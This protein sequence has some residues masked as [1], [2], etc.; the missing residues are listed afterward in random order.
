MIAES[1]KQKKRYNGVDVTLRAIR[2]KIH[3]YFTGASVACYEWTR[4]L[5]VECETV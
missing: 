2:G 3:R 4:N 1:L 5:F